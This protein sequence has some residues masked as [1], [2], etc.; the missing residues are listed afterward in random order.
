VGARPSK[1]QQLPGALG[2]KHRLHPTAPGQGQPGGPG[3]T[4]KSPYHQA[5][6][7]QPGKAKVKPEK[8]VTGPGPDQ[9]GQANARLRLSQ[10]QALLRQFKKSE[11]CQIQS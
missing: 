11:K 3:I 7:W 8:R 9:R 2:A 4:A 10:R 5:R 1:A 6:S